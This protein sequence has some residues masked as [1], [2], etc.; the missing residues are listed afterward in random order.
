MELIKTI[1]K[2]IVCKY[3]KSS[4][5]TYTNTNSYKSNKETSTVLYQTHYSVGWAIQVEL[6]K[7]ETFFLWEGITF[8]T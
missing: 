3:G 7:G 2:N 4:V 5:I 6:Q 8:L 1:T